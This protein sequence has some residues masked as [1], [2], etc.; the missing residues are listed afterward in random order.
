MIRLT[1][2]QKEKNRELRHQIIDDIMEIQ[3][4]KSL[5]LLWSMAERA[6]GKELTEHVL[7]LDDII[8]SMDIGTVYKIYKTICS[9]EGTDF[10]SEQTKELC[11]YEIDQYI[12][13]GGSISEIAEPC[14][15]LEG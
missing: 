5:N 14:R 3:D 15:T 4:V 2:E 13:R 12:Q 10:A 7:P 1:Y 6:R 8:G 9:E 11:Q